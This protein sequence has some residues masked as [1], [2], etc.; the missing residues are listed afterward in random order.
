MRSRRLVWLLFP[1]FLLVVLL[2]LT[3]SLWYATRTLHR[4]HLDQTARTLEERARLIEHALVS[5][6]LWTRPDVANRLARELGERAHSRVTVILSDGTVVG[7]S[8]ENPAIMDNHAGRPEVRTA[9]T[10]G[11]GRSLRHSDT[12]NQ[13]LFYVALPVRVQERIAAV[14]RVAVPVTALDQALAELLSRLV[15]GGLVVAL[16]AALVSLYLA[17]RLSRPLEAM[18]QAAQDFGSGRLTRRVPV[19][20]SEELCQLARTLNQMAEQL[21]QRM[22]SIVAQRSEIEAIL[23]SM[24]EGVLAVDTDERLLR[25]NRAAIAMLGLSGDNLQGRSVQELIRRSDL[26]AF[27]GRALQSATPVEEDLVLRGP[28]DLFLQL[29][30]APLRDE[31]GRM[32]GAVVVLNDISR[33]RRLEQV[34]RD[35]VANVSHE[36]KTPLTAIQGFVETL[37]ADAQP[38]PERTRHF[39]AIV[40]R[41]TARLRAIIDDLL[42]LSRLERDEAA[43]H[44]ELIQQPLLPIARAALQDCQVQADRAG[45]ELVCEVPEELAAPVD[46]ALLERALSNLIDNAVK[47]SPEGSRVRI[48]AEHADGMV[49]MEV[50]DQGCG[51]AAEHLSRLFERFYRVDRGRSRQLGGTGLGLAIVKH[52]A[53]L[54]GGRVEVDSTPGRGSRFAILLPAGDS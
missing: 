41:Q 52:I 13:T 5:D 53:Q 1:T 38:D 40:L 7:D 24:T 35:F 50:I 54:H 4:F 33:L 49:R 47:Y 14:V 27:I 25:I 51:I 16:L 45:I 23:A 29:Q 6:S 15:I 39:L 18:R 34:R 8:D 10:G 2:T 43:E 3:G 44:I 36:L 21:D 31:A 32:R 48:R 26:Q 22:R 30:G 17:R 37:L 42:Q 28:E 20:G 11:V 12:V 46:G 9:L 19:Q